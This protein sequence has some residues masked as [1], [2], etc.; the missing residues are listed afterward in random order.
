MSLTQHIIIIDDA[1][2]EALSARSRQS[3][4]DTRPRNSSAES[5]NDTAEAGD[6]VVLDRLNQQSLR[7]QQERENA[8]IVS[9]LR[10]SYVPP[11]SHKLDI[12][13]KYR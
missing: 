12:S 8:K 3:S 10:T 11:P 4:V 13:S 5:T 7:Q 6:K 2:N 1:S 9:G